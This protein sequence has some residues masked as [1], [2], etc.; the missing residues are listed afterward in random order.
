MLGYGHEVW[1]SGGYY[2]W[3]PMVIPFLGCLFGG[4]LYDSCIYTGESPVNTPWLGFKRL[5]LPKQTAQAIIE[6]E[7]RVRREGVV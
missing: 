7:Q 2:F 3:I 6:H 4:F 1:S 5:L